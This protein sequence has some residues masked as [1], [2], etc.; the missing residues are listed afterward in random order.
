MPTHRE[1]CLYGGAAMHVCINTI[2]S[3]SNNKQRTTTSILFIYSPQYHFNPK[4]RQQHWQI[5]T[6]RERGRHNKT[7]GTLQIVTTRTI[8]NLHKGFCKVTTMPF[9]FGIRAQLIISGEGGPSNEAGGNGI[10]MHHVYAAC[11]PPY[12]L[13]LAA[14]KSSST[15]AH[16]FLTIRTSSIIALNLFF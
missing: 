2:R 14:H 5:S 8:S 12:A 15:A 7:A 16:S 10:M 6:T 4:L 13:G 11:L 3:S 9:E 1:K